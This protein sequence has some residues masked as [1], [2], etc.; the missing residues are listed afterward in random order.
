MI[1]SGIFHRCSAL[2]TF[3]RVRSL[4]LYQRV[5]VRLSVCG[6]AT[7]I[8]QLTCAALESYVLQQAMPR[9]ADTCYRMLTCDVVIMG[10]LDSCIT[11]R[12]NA[13]EVGY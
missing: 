12:R 3:P 1:I 4:V 10:R 5:F 2:S 9:A 13:V 8:R 6:Q 7:S 11:S